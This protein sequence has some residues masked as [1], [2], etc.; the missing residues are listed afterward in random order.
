MPRK[1]LEQLNMMMPPI[2][3]THRAAPKAVEKVSQLQVD[4]ECQG[5]GSERLEEKITLMAKKTT[6]TKNHTTHPSNSS[7]QFSIPNNL[8]HLSPFF[9]FLRIK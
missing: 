4:G 2:K 3:V 1:M 8:E 5:L 6:T 9:F 7:I